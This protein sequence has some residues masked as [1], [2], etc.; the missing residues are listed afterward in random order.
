[1]FPVE[2]IAFDRL[3]GTRDRAIY[4][5]QLPRLSYDGQVTVTGRRHAAGGTEQWIAA[6]LDHMASRSSYE[7]TCGRLYSPVHLDG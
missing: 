6:E 2:S 7:V 4:R 5:V 3:D 1:M